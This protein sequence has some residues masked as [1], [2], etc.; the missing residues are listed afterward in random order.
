MIMLHGSSV[1][2]ETFFVA[3]M[4]TSRYWINMSL[5]CT[6]G[7]FLSFF[8]QEVRLPTCVSH[9]AQDLKRWNRCGHHVP[10]AS[11][12]VDSLVE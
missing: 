8:P 5:D 10:A 9:E 4:T 12:V 2:S 1:F 3:T 7:H 6:L 11:N